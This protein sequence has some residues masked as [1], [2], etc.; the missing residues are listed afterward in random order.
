VIDSV[1]RNIIGG[2][3]WNAPAI[4]PAGC[5][6]SGADVQQ[7]VTPREWKSV[8]RDSYDGKID[9]PHRCAAVHEA[10]G[11][12]RAT[13]RTSVAQV[14]SGVSSSLTRRKW[15]D[16]TMCSKPAHEMLQKLHACSEST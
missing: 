12:S 8:I 15:A 11:A 5:G 14:P 9:P 1:G 16:Q 2:G 3:A 13:R 6:G 4:G 10:I 7:P